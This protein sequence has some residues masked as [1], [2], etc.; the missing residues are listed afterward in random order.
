MSAQLLSYYS[1]K[2]GLFV[3]L[4][5]SCMGWFIIY[6][7]F[8]PNQVEYISLFLLLGRL[9]TGIGSGL[10]ISFSV[11]YLIEIALFEHRGKIV[12]LIQ[13]GIAFGITISY[14]DGMYL[15]LHKMA[16]INMLFIVMLIIF[17]YYIPESS[18][19]SRKIGQH[20]DLNKT[21]KN[22]HEHVSY[23]Y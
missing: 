2:F 3:S 7:S 15:P 16:L 13:I 10:S 19:W 1:R 8:I 18:K 12:L 17:I 6:C 14:F 4:I 11:I 9:L 22:L 5:I 20:Q 21:N 23:I